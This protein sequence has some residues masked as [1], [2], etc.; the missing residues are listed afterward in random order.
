MLH[1]E[2]FQAPRRSPFPTASL[3]YSECR[4]ATR[5]TKSL[6]DVYV[7]GDMLERFESTLEVILHRLHALRHIRAQRQET[8]GLLAGSD[9]LAHDDVVRR[10]HGLVLVAVD[11]DLAARD[12]LDGQVGD[13]ALVV[14]R[15]WVLPVDGGVGHVCVE[16][17]EDHG[18][19]A[20]VEGGDF[21]G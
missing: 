10:F 5:S 18:Q 19:G 4:W 2:P 11:G 21:F 20:D 17:A 13:G 8:L 14:F 3:S 7:I 9:A 12:V 16:G 6:V 15:E 1:L